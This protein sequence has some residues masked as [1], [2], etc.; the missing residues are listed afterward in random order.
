MGTIKIKQLFN[1]QLY[2]LQVV[3]VEIPKTPCSYTESLW[4]CYLKVK[5]NSLSNKTLKKNEWLDSHQTFFPCCA[6]E[7]LPFIPCL[8][9]QSSKET[10]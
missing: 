3:L 1:V 9:L 6:L 7:R 4:T 8:P 10:L 2:A 5:R